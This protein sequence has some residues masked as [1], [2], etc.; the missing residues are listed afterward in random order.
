MKKT[1]LFFICILITASIYGYDIKKDFDYSYTPDYTIKATNEASYY[2]DSEGNK[3]FYDT[4]VVMDYKSSI[5]YRWYCS[6]ETDALKKYR[7]LIS[8]YSTSNQIKKN[9][10]PSIE[11]KVVDV[12]TSDNGKWMYCSL[13]EVIETDYS[14]ITEEQLL[15]LLFDKIDEG[16]ISDE[17]IVGLIAMYFDSFE[18][19]LDALF[20]G[21]NPKEI[22]DEVVFLI[23][24]EYLK[25]EKNSE[26]IEAIKNELSELFSDNDQTLIEE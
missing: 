4:V 16:E 2:I 20:D 12:N 13:G 17:A 22:M 26:K 19:F 15:D 5:I 14:N 8:E 7:E 24:D 21:A 18:D 3:K 9:L 6:T 1:I 11:K 23:I 10:I 25:T